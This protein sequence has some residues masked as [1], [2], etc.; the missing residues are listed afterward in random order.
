VIAVVV[1]HCR[2]EGDRT[3][4]VDGALIGLHD[5]ISY[6]GRED[7]LGR[8]ANNLFGLEC[9]NLRKTPID[10]LIPSVRPFHVDYRGNVVE[11]GTFALLAHAQLFFHLQA[12]GD[13]A[14]HRVDLP[15]LGNA[16]G[17]P[18]RPVRLA[19]VVQQPETKLG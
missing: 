18:F 8:A 17:A 12:G 2:L 10:I 15:F 4:A 6:F 3:T 5:L 13:V 16:P 19:V 14:S 1:T 7:R 9:E 11:N